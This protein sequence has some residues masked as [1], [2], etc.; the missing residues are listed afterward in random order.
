MPRL[1]K[2]RPS[3]AR[4]TSGSPLSSDH[5]E[6]LTVGVGMKRTEPFPPRRCGTDPFQV[7]NRLRSHSPK[8]L[9]VEQEWPIDQDRSGTPGILERNGRSLVVGGQ[10]TRA[11]QAPEGGR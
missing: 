1:A 4:A 11:A 9:V 2:R 6:G 5:E 10:K 8:K 7:T 3:P